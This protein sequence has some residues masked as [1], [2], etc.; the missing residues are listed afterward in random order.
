[1]MKKIISI[2]SIFAMPGITGEANNSYS[3]QIPR[4]IIP[5]I[6]N[7]EKFMRSFFIIGT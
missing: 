7:T 2:A 4:G 6:S 5:I 1:M 3:P